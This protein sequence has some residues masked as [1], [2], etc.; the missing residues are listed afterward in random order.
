VGIE[1]ELGCQAGCWE[2]AFL[3][4]AVFL[5]S[6]TTASEPAELPLAR[7]WS[8]VVCET[9]QRGNELFAETVNEVKA[10]IAAQ[11]ACKTPELTVKARSAAWMAAIPAAPVTLVGNTSQMKAC[12]LHLRSSHSHVTFS[13]HTSK[14]L[15]ASTVS[16]AADYIL[17]MYTLH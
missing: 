1:I 2:E 3:G 11:H 10:G 5:Q 12:Q 16:A 14:F 6:R 9:E 8:G 7:R 13:R 17:R 15:T 4:A